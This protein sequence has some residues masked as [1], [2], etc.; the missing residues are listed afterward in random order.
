MLRQAI[1]FGGKKLLRISQ[2][3]H[4]FQLRAVNIASALPYNPSVN[5]H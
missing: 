1:V 4:S 2:A 5:S 3:L